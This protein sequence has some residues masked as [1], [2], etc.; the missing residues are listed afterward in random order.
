MR[1]DLHLVFSHKENFAENSFGTTHLTQLACLRKM[2]WIRWL[3]A[4]LSQRRPDFG[5]ELVRVEF[6]VDRVA[7]GQVFLR[8]L[9]LSP[10]NI[11]PSWLCI[12]IHHLGNEQ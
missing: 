6:M 7:L 10:V 2:T 3:V 12:L 11:I 1:I 5:L 9:R 8:G 4:G